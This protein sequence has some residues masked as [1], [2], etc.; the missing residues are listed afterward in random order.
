M[1]ANCVKQRAFTVHK[2]SLREVVGSEHTAK[3]GHNS[4]MY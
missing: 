2:P 3:Q 4:V 1:K